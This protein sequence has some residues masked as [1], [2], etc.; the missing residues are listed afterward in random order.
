[1]LA[2]GSCEVLQG[3]SGHCLNERA[4]YILHPTNQGTKGVA[5]AAAQDKDTGTLRAP[6]NTL[7]QQQGNIQAIN[8]L[9]S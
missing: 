6:H 3:L 4:R 1:V 5:S 2:A 9:C 7:I 8:R